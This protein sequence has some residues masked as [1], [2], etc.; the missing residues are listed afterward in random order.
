MADKTAGGESQT[1]PTRRLMLQA[2]YG[3][4]VMWSKGFAAEETEAAFARAS[5]LSSQTQSSAERSMV[6]YARWIRSFVR[7]EMNSARMIAESFLREAEAEGRTGEAAL[8]RRAV[9]STC[10]FQGKLA[11]A[12]S[13]TERALADIVSEQDID[14][15]RQFGTDTRILAT[16]YL[17]LATW[18]LGDVE[19]ARRLIE[20]AIRDGHVSG[21]V[22][23]IVHTY[24]VRAILEAFRNDP[25]ASLFAAELLL[26]FAREHD[27]A[28]YAAWGENWSIWARGR[29]QD[30]QIGA[31][32]L[33][34]SLARYLQQGNA[35]FA[36]LYYGFVADLE[37]I[38]GRVDDALASVDAGLKLAKETGERWTDPLLLCSKGKILLQT[39]PAN[40]TP[41][42]Q[43]FRSAIETAQQQG[44]RG[45]GLRAALSLAKLNQSTGRPA[46][47]CSV[48]ALALEGFSPTP[49]MPEIAEALALMDR[50][51]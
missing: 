41:G 5:D 10:L 14:A 12:R 15:R 25:A 37:A 27:I 20:V 3:R 17:S 35:I 21:H 36:P 26:E 42:E 9:G 46:E 13:H 28:L 38:A 16:T 30:P 49:E 45:F 1:T 4:A 22:A 24:L 44:S 39:D 47:A 40:P 7:S 33:W 23:T 29:L 11:L 19:Y 8:A 2:D 34:H 48:L 31:R 18:L 43:A 50:L 51:A 6:Y 32:E